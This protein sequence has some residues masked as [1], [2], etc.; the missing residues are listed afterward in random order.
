MMVNLSKIRCSRITLG[1][2]LN[3]S[4]SVLESNQNDV[5]GKNLLNMTPKP[6]SEEKLQILGFLIRHKASFAADKNHHSLSTSKYIL[7]RAHPIRRLRRY[8]SMARMG[9]CQTS[10]RQAASYAT[11]L[12]A[13][14]NSGRGK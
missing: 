5:N 4:T 14:F 2:L 13:I 1:I 8:R 12:Q 7:L 11:P 3:Q 9:G 10:T 6:F